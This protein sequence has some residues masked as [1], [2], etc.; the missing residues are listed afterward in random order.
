[1]HVGAEAHLQEVLATHPEFHD[2]WTK[3]RKLKEDPR[4]FP[5]GRFLRKYSLDELPQFWNAFTGT[6]SVV[7]PRA[8]LPEEI[9][10][11]DEIKAHKILSTRPGITGLWQISGRNLLSFE[12]RI[13]HDMRYVDMQSLK[14]D[15]YVIGKTVTVVLKSKGAY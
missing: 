15:M 12:E 5:F 2:E 7:G 6:M 8:Y 11:M 14:Y 3:F 4:V 9:D 13:K 1:M 10:E